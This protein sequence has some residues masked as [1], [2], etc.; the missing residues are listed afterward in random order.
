M[1][2]PQYHAQIIPHKIT[3]IIK[4]SEHLIDR[5]QKSFTTCKKLGKIKNLQKQYLN[6]RPIKQFERQGI[7]S[8]R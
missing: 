3:Y 8:G 4:K 7:A 6:K 2:G 5:Y 1:R